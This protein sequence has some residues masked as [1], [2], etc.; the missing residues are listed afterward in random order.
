MKKRIM[1]ARFDAEPI[2][3]AVFELLA[4]GRVVAEYQDDA[5]RKQ[6]EDDGLWTLATGWVTPADGRA[7]FDALDKAFANSSFWFVRSER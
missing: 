2:E 1:C 6:I 4:D 3:L 7:F 5:L